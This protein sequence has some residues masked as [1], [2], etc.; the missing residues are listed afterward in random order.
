[1]KYANTSSDHVVAHLLITAHY[2]VSA[3]SQLMARKRRDTTVNIFDKA[4]LQ[5]I[6]PELKRLQKNE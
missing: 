3:F 5:D 4:T 1:V 2:Q 6:I